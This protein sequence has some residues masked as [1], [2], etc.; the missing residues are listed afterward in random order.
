M[1][2]YVQ[3]APPQAPADVDALPTGIGAVGISSADADMVEEG[4]DGLPGPDALSDNEDEFADLFG[5]EE[6]PITS[7]KH[8]CPKACYV[9][10]DCHADEKD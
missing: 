9:A 1:T 4:V 6:D 5:P 8:D 7:D 10:G 3:S 2:Y